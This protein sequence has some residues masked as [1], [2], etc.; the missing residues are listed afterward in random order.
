MGSGENC[1]LDYRE[2][3]S[4]DVQEFHGGILLVR[5][6]VTFLGGDLPLVHGGSNPSRVI[7]SHHEGIYGELLL[8]RAMVTETVLQWGEVVFGSFSVAIA[9][10]SG[11]VHDPPPG[12]CDHVYDCHGCHQDSG[13]ALT[14]STGGLV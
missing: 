9:I 7:S 5:L 10:L 1:Y 6:N 3:N 12:Y 11:H 14:S 13:Y 8:C 4:H 2:K